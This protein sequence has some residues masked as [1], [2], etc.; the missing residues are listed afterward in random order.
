MQIL[1]P[2]LYMMI[3]MFVF[4]PKMSE[5][6]LGCW[7]CDAILFL[8]FPSSLKMSY[9]GIKCRVFIR[10]FSVKKLIVLINFK[11]DDVMKITDYNVIFCKEDEKLN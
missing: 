6:L 3:F 11:L 1:V 4:D 5:F 10:M 9:N 2:T 8:K 7:S